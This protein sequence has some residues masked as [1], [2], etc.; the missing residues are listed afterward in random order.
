MIE[1]EI[2]QILKNYNDF[3]ESI[4]QA[5]KECQEQHQECERKT[6]DYYHALELDKLT[7]HELAR[8]TKLQREN[9]LERRKCKDY[10]EFL[11]PLKK[12]ISDGQ[13]THVNRQLAQALRDMQKVL[14]SRE[15]R[16]YAKRSKGNN[17]KKNSP[18][19]N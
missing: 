9:L 4:N 15:N 3:C 1:P 10:I 17:D 2:I 8:A 12:W 16:K 13:T 5:F 11:T 14:H 7:Y 6:I 18:F 19:K